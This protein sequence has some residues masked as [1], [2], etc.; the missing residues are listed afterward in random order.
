[1]S[2]QAKEQAQ[3]PEVKPAAPAKK[4]AAP[5]A[6]PK[7]MR[8]YNRLNEDVIL[9]EGENAIMIPPRGQVVVSEENL[10]EELPAGVIVTAFAE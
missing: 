8:A 4:P 3:E 6:A 2:E 7:L 1:M 9:G 10:P 5:K